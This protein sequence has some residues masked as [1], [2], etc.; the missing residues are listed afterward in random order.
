M[1]SPGRHTSEIIVAAVLWLSALLLLCFFGWMLL[2]ILFRGAGGLS[3]SFLVSPPENS[4]R[5]GGVSTI[6]LSTLWILAVAIGVATPVGLGAAAWLA[7]ITRA[8]GWASIAVRRSLDALAGAPSII[9]GLFGSVF[10]CEFLGLGF[11]I[12]SG[13]LTLAC[14][15]LP[16]IIRATEE[17][18]RAIPEEHRLAAASLGFSQFTTLVRV[19]LPQ[20]APGMVVG[21]ILGVGRALAE[22]AALIFT[23]GYVT[24]APQSW[25]DSGRAL[26]VHIWE[27]SNNVAGGD[28][29]A[30]TSALVLLLLL[31]VINGAASWLS[32][33][34]L[35]RNLSI[36]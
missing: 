10:F 13:G 8:Q 32:H 18:F 30:A 6:L 35:Q 5:E 20:A 14:M 34:L 19:L 16:L 7:E 29:N 31:L 27:L 4:G 17:G 28:R 9:F 12:L 25:H 3:L 15:S 22:T 21:V 24:R 33:R 26:S 2:D 1:L 11:S 36:A 23:S